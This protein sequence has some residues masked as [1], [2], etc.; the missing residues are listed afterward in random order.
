MLDCVRRSPYDM[1]DLAFHKILDRHI[2]TGFQG[3]P[4]W[5]HVDV[6]PGIRQKDRWRT[7]IDNTGRIPLGCHL[8]GRLP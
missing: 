3:H 8:T 1:S 6:L 5:Q 2:D 4:F 7:S